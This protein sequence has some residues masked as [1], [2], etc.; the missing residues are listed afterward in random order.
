MEVLEDPVGLHL[1]AGPFLLIY[2]RALLPEEE[3]AKLPWPER[4]KVPLPTHNISLF[5]TPGV[6]E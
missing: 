6:V 3:N 2:S 1:G 4:I 5:L